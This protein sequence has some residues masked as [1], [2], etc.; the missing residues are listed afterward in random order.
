MIEIFVI[1]IYSFEICSF[2][3]YKLQETSDI[4]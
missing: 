4:D 2:K 1:Y 3:N